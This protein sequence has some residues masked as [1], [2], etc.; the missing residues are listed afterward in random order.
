MEYNGKETVNKA[1]INYFFPNW[2]TEPKVTY[3]L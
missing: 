1:K 3:I 2:S